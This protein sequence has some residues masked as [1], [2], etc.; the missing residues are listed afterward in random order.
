MTVKCPGC[1][2]KFNDE[3][4]WVLCPHN[5]LD[6]E[7]DAKYCRQHDMFDCQFCKVFLHAPRMTSPGRIYDPR[8]LSDCIDEISA[9]RPRKQ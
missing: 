7:P 5:P 2:K 1:G 6:V 3:T 8:P 4:S 9:S